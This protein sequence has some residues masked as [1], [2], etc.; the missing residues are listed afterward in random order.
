MNLRDF[1]DRHD[2]AGGG[3]V[4]NVLPDWAPIWASRVGEDQFGRWAELLVSGVIQRLRWIAPGSFLMGSSRDEQALAWEWMQKSLPHPAPESGAP[5]ETQHQV[6][7]TCGFWLADTPCTQGLWQAVMG[8][9][10]SAFHDDPLRPVEQVSW[11]DC[12]LFFDKLRA[13]VSGLTAQLPTEAQWEYSCRAGT[14]TATYAGPLLIHGLYDSPILD[15]IAWY[16]GNSG[17]NPLQYGHRHAGSH[18]VGE[19]RPNP[20]DLYDTIG[21]VWELCADWYDEYPAEPVTDPTGPASGSLRVDRG[22]SWYNYAASCRAALR[23]GV[24]PGFR[25]NCLGFRFCI[26]GQ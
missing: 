12:Q 11:N 3:D 18:R 20:W 5:A 17:M 14:T 24:D 10:P 21:N 15:E 4:L 6:T 9:N 19:K 25:L 7:L 1:L 23:Y 2:L 13:C 8:G 16:A 26:P 22:A